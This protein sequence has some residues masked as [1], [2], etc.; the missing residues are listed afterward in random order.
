M[1]PEDGTARRRDRH[2]RGLRR[3]LLS[4]VAQPLPGGAAVA[5]PAWRS[6]RDRFDDLVRDALD[7][8]AP[9]WGH[10]LATLEV[11]VEDVPDTRRGGLPLHGVVADDTAGGAVPLGVALPATRERHARLV[12]F[13]RPVEARAE[14]PADL[15]DLVHEV[16]VDLLAEL[17]GL[18][19]DEIDP[20]QR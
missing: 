12:V 4:P 7:D 9:R 10:A 2:G 16:V 18:S 6:R 3:P 15:G 17:L 20:G 8:L 19:P 14:D 13:R 11:A 1:A 5:V